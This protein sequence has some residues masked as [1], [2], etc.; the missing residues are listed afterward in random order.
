[1]VFIKQ[2][3]GYRIVDF[4]S[5]DDAL[6][7]CLTAEEGSEEQDRA[8][9][10]CLDN[11]PDDLREKLHDMLIRKKEKQCGCGCQQKEKLGF[12]LE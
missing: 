3:L 2:K 1:M 11:A 7:V 12:I 10:Y 6:E 4:S 9:I 5:F 8:I